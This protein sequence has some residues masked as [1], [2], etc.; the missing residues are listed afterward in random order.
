MWWNVY[1]LDK[2]VEDKVWTIDEI[3]LSATFVCFLL[4]EAGGL[5]EYFA[6]PNQQTDNKK[7]PDVSFF[8][9]TGINKSLLL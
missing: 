7:D 8:C 9:N 3:L 4:A 2:L 1:H 6:N 5:Q